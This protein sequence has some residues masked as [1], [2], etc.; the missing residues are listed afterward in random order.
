M[1]NS[2]DFFDAIFCIN[3]DKRPDRWIHAQEQFKK[4]GILDKVKRFSA[5][6]RKDG[7]LGCIKSHLEII[8]YAQ[9]NNLNNVL[10]FEDDVVFMD[11]NVELIMG[12][13]INQIP[14]NWEMLYLGANLHSPLSKFSDNLVLLVN[15]FS[16]HAVAYNKSIFNFFIK[17]YN[18]MNEVTLQ[19]D[20]LD[21]W[22]ANH[23][24]TRGKTFLVKPLLATQINDYS[25]IVKSNVDY[26]FIKERYK[27]FVL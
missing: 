20:I 9:K 12:N 16:T 22:I 26:S 4:I 11:E 17:K 24:Q 5:I 21:V 14:E 10:I 15:G 19:S 1:D 25:D 7:R 13:V 27:K 23:I 2:F 18:K 3:L 8:K 6:E